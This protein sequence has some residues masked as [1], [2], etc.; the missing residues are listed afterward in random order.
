MLGGTETI[1]NAACRLIQLSFQLCVVSFVLNCKNQSLSFTLNSSQIDRLK[2]HYDTWQAASK[3][4]GLV[5]YFEPLKIELND[6]LGA[7]KDITP[8]LLFINLPGAS[9]N[10]SALSTSNA[11]DVT[12]NNSEP[13]PST[14]KEKKSKSKYF[15]VNCL[16]INSTQ[17]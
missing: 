8:D 10:E 14:S 3:K 4:S 17:M 13:Q 15:S 6:C 1:T 9:V 11:S 16:F 7:L 2:K 5:L 12:E